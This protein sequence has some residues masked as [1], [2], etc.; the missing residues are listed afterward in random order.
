MR[1]RTLSLP[2]LAL[3]ALAAARPERRT[4]TARARQA[5]TPVTVA[6]TIAGKAYN[7]KG[8]GECTFAP[9]ASIYGVRAQQYGVRLSGT[10]GLRS[11]GL[12]VWRPTAGGADQMNL[13]MTVGSK[14]HRIDTVK[15]GGKKAV[16]GGT[17]SVQ[18]KAMGGRFTID[19]KDADGATIRGTIE[20]ARFAEPNPV[21]G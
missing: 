8:S 5:P 21:A 4:A 14:S 3:C 18:R 16:G 13:H 10:A 1:I 6:L 12:T 9:V 17:V 19:S 11:L 2:A 20:C 15:G 7:G